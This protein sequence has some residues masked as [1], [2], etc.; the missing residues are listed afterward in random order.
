MFTE[1][2]LIAIVILLSHRNKV[3]IH[4][5]FH[6]FSNFDRYLFFKKLVDKKN[7]KVQ[8]DFMPKTNEEYISVT[9]VCNRFVDSFR[10]LSSSLDSLVKTLANEDFKVLKK[11]FSDE[12][13]YLNKK[14]ANPYEF[15]IVLMNI[16][17][18]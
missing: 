17:T 3:D 8:F 10:I 14:L 1:A 11:G 4:H 6:I 12:W 2:Q 7:D 9:Y 13:K 16:K 5:F 15:S 18:I